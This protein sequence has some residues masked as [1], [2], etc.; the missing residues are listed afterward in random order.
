MKQL[1]LFNEECSKMSLKDILSEAPNFDVTLKLKVSALAPLSMNNS[2]PGK[3]YPSGY[4][5]SESMVL[6][7]I[8]NAIGLYL[9]E[10][11]R[12]EL[13][14]ITKKKTS[15][16][17]DLQT[18]VS[19]YISV[20]QHHLRIDHIT[21]S[22]AMKFTDFFSQQLNRS[23]GDARLN[24]GA[25]MSYEL[26]K[27][28]SELKNIS[29]IAAA[30]RNELSPEK[31]QELGEKDEEKIKQLGDEKKK[32]IDLR[33]KELNKLIACYYTTPSTRE[34][35]EPLNDYIITISTSEYLDEIIRHSLFDPESPLFLGTNDGWVD[36]EVINE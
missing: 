9:D 7:M 12:K 17:K 32:S 4:K 16:G 3:F 2:V 20:L 10:G 13:S 29:S 1:S 25:N 8:E 31:I 21:E 24:G 36:V 34:Y 23:E 5:P 33:E 18:S 26:V 14:K 27:Y 30:K 35:I 22:F 15:A 6:G 11:D 19:Q 28:L